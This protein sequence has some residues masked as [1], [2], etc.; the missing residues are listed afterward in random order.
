MVCR[1]FDSQKINIMEN[2]QTNLE[3]AAKIKKKV[4]EKIRSR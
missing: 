1:A 4:S 3:V 2:Y